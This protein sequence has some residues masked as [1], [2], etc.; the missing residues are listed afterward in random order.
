MRKTCM[1]A[2]SLLSLLLLSL[3]GIA[4]A[5]NENYI[6]VLYQSSNSPPTIDGTYI[7]DDDWIASGKEEFGDGAAFHDQW[8]MS[9]NIYCCIV[10]VTDNTTDAGDK[11][12]ICF[13]GTA[14]GG[15]NPPDGGPNPTQYDKKLEVTGHPGSQTI[16]WY[17]GNGSDWVTATASGDLLELAQSLTTTPTI[18]PDHYVYEMILNFHDDT[19]LGSPLVGYEW[20]QFVSY[21]DEDTG[22][23]QQWPPADATPAGSPD[24]PENWGGITYASNANPTVTIPEPLTI[25]AIVLLS[26]AALVISFYWLR[27]K[28]TNRMVKHN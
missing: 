9:P 8:L 12:T 17:I 26:S 18:E 28:S 22:E 25:G 10:E 15:S 7:V 3:V 4:A 23:T 27:K 21:Y 6:H 19:S 1:F 14:A 2:F 13:D 11:L 24:V 20:A 5:Y 16:Q